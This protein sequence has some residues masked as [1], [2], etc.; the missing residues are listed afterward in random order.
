MSAGKYKE[1]HIPKLDKMIRADVKFGTPSDDCRGLGICQVVPRTTWRYEDLNRSRCM[2][3]KAY[4][5]LSDN[6]DLE[7]HFVR[8]TMCDLTIRR[9][10][11]RKTFLIKEGIELPKTI[12]NQFNLRGK[13]IEPGEYSVRETGELITVVFPL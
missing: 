7:L 1:T 4:I 3:A 2:Q 6:G 8:C 13:R 12:A 11:N 9:F 5:S 10:F